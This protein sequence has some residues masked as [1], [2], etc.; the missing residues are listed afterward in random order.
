MGK[1]ITSQAYSTVWT[2]DKITYKVPN[3]WTFNDDAPGVM[4]LHG[5]GGDSAQQ[6][7]TPFLHAQALVE[8]L[9]FAFVGIDLT[10]PNAYGHPATMNLMT[11]LYNF[12]Q[13]IVKVKGV[14]IGMMGWSMGGSAAL[15]WTRRNPTLVNFLQLWSPLLDM[16][17]FHN[18]GGYTPAYTPGFTLASTGLPSASEIDTAYSTIGTAGATTTTAT[19]S[20]TIPAV[21]GG[22]VTVPLTTTVNI[23]DPATKGTDSRASQI[24]INSVTCTYTGISGNSLTG[25]QSTTG[26]TVAVVNGTVVS[27]NYINNV[28]GYDPMKNPAAWGSAGANVPVKIIHA[29]DDV[30]V[31]PA[32]STYWAGQAGSPVTLRSTQPTGGHNGQFFNVPYQETLADFGA[33]TWS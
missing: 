1:A 7:T 12:M 13:N 11:E 24:I 32:A 31:P 27:T 17:W 25:V 10:G 20:V 16:D 4:Y 22:T 33:R 8:S 18:T 15:E 6:W 9:G 26:S 23:A 2:T 14:K 19:G 30:T 28:P 3:N 29:S 5:R 21:G